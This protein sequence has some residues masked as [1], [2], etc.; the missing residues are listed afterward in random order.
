MKHS[1]FYFLILLLII[2]F[3]SLR[4]TAHAS[5]PEADQSATLVVFE[6]QADDRI[7]KLRGY[8]A[9]F[10]SPLVNKAPH[11]IAEADRFFLD[12]KLVPAIAGLESTY[13]KR[14]PRGTF[15]AWGWGIP[16]PQHRGIAFSDW[17]N[18]ITTVT[19]GLRTNYVDRGA[20]S[21][22]QIGRRYASS[23]TWAVRVRHI[24]ADIDHYT[25]RK[26]SHLLVTI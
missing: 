23:P 2:G 20:S 16:T 13:G 7:A 9:S 12:W 10:H 15:N 1:T 4:S 11:F 5:Q 19:E 14:L 17:E 18:G 24:M 8:L 26:P 6:V 21:I 25:P 22:E 3:S